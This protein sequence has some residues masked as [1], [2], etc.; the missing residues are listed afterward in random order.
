[1][2]RLAAASVDA[3]ASAATET[4]AKTRAYP[5][6]FMLALHTIPGKDRSWE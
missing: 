4:T 5:S 2:R 6:S 1:M 3:V